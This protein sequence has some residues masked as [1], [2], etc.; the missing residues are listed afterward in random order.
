MNAPDD[1]RAWLRFADIDITA[2]RVLDSEE[3]SDALAYAV[4]SHAHQAAEKYLK[5]LLVA[6]D[7]EPPRI[8][9]LPELLRRAITHVSYLD[10]PDIWDA[11]TGLNAYYIPTRYPVHAGGTTDPIT[12]REAAEALAW[13]ESIA[14]A[15]RPY[16]LA[17]DR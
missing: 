4:C 7:E 8:H 13:T 12:A 10:H 2:A 3:R 15:V 16:L 11:T 14:S 9:A 6:N 1:P 5:G 17:E